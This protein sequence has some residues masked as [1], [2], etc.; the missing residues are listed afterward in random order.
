[1]KRLLKRGETS[2][3]PDD[4]DEAVIRNRIAEYERKDRAAEG[5]LHRPTQIQG[6]HGVGSIDEITQ[7][8]VGAIAAIW[9]R[10][11]PNFIASHPASKRGAEGGAGSRHL[12][13]EKYMPRA[14]PMVVMAAAAAM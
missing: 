10:P 1:M 8:L 12:R 2:G 7:R 3:R 5:L 6:I 9:A 13:R 14:G 4:R 11:A